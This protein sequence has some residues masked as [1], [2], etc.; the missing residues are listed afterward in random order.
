MIQ[1][2]SPALVLA[3]ASLSRRALLEA[4]G[5]RFEARA[6]A[7]DE[8]AVKAAGQAEGARPDDTTLLLAELKARRVRDPDALVIGADQLLVCE[9]QWFDK[10]LDLPAARRQLQTLRGKTH[11]LVTA[12]ACLRGGQVVWHAIARPRLRMRR[13]GDAFLDA[14][15]ALEGERVLSSVGAY[16]LEGPG[17]HLFDQVEGEHA[18][19]LGLPMLPLLGFLRQHGVLPDAPCS[20]ANP[21]L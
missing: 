19:I 11:E 8:A 16:R 21:A 6:S 18:A 17:I 2:A 10:P 4:A 1:A 12:I 14:Y 15:L 5:L 20:G 9:G 13:F 7:V 3:S